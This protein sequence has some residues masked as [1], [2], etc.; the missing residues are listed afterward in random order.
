[1]AAPALGG[2]EV[3]VMPRREV[4]PFHRAA[5][6]RLRRSM[7]D[8]EAALWTRLRGHRLLDASFRRQAPI[9]P[10][11]VDFFC[12]AAHLVVEVDGGGHALPEARRRDTRRTAWLEGAGYR[13]LRFWN[14]EVLNELD[15]VLE[16][17]VAALAAASPRPD[18]APPL[19]GPPPRGGREGAVQPACHSS[20]ASAVI[21]PSPLEGEGQGGGAEASPPTTDPD[22][23][24]RSS[25]SETGADQ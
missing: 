7:T 13:V 5:A 22:V 11:I 24:T 23:P 20:E 16:A 25:A 18:A 12:A 15:G 14:T 2:S 1:M 6:R 9:G 8:A 3:S 17:I 4:L 21:V 19:P 10:Y